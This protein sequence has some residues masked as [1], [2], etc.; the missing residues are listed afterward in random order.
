MYSSELG[1]IVDHPGL[2]VVHMDDHMVHHGHGVYETIV[3]CEGYLYQLDDH[4]E[5][6]KS[7]ADMAGLTVP[8][9]DAQL[10]RIVL[11]TAAAG[12]RLNGKQ[13]DMA[14]PSHMNVI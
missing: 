6:L 11:D 8:V 14:M 2:M 7:S 13:H 1:G 3:V 12:G 9:S 10:K 4:L 5:R